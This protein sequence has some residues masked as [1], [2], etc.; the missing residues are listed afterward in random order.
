MTIR[1]PP[2]SLSGG[3]GSP[4]LRIRFSASKMT[5]IWRVAITLTLAVAALVI[6]DKTKA[7][8]LYNNMN[9]EAVTSGPTRNELR[10]KVGD[11]IVGVFNASTSPPKE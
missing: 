2:R 9:T 1:V 6:A 8:D 7:A 10:P 4:G 5:R 3:K 11:G